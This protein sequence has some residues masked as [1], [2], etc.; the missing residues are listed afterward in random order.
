ML[1][2]QTSDPKYLAWGRRANA[3]VRRTV[4]IDGPAEVRGGVKG[5]FPVNGSYGAFEYLNW[6]AKFCA[7]A[8]MM[9]LDLGGN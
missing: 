5:S 4:Q 2:R 1:Y 3:Y 8:Q 9:E 7:D 6:A